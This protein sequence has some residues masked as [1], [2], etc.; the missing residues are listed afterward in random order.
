MREHPPLTKFAIII[1]IEQFY[2]TYSFAA[3]QMCFSE[4][5]QDCKDYY[6]YLFRCL[7]IKHTSKHFFFPGYLHNLC[8]T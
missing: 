3:L 5:L 6:L 8:I 7:S 4:V 2:E 1:I